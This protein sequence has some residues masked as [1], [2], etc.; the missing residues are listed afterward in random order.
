[1]TPK[2]LRSLAADMGAR[3][4]DE[5]AQ[6]CLSAANQ[7]EVLAITLHMLM[8]ATTL[9]H[10]NPMDLDSLAGYNSAKSTAQR[11]L[12]DI[13]NAELRGRPLADGPA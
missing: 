7:I 9:H 2:E 11:V 8:A 4:P 10:R 1:M 5:A 12:D 13:P 3:H 6:A